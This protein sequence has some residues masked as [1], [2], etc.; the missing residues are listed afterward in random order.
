MRKN[1]RETLEENTLDQRVLNDLKRAMFSYDHMIRLPTPFSRQQVVYIS[2]SSYVSPV[3]LTDE[4]RGSWST[5]KPWSSINHSALSAQGYSLWRFLCEEVGV[6]S[7]S[8]SSLSLYSISFRL[9]WTWHIPWLQGYFC[10]ISKR[11]KSN[12]RRVQLLFNS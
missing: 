2:K 12:L 1:C 4:R 5:R 7:L 9:S 10:K 6:S 11:R 8:L 3:E